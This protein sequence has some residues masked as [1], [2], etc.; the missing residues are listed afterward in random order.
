MEERKYRP[1]EIPP[2]VMKLARR[3]RAMEHSDDVFETLLCLLAQP[4]DSR[5][6]EKRK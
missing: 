1:E 3:I 5:K 2:N 4:K 6:V